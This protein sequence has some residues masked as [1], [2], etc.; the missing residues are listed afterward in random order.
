[1]K[2]FHTLIIALFVLVGT[3]ASQTISLTGTMYT[4]DFNTLSNTAGSTTN[5]LAIPGWFMTETGGGARDNEQY[6]VDPGGS[7]TGDTYSYGSA[8][9]TDRALGGLQAGTLIPNFGAAFT[10]NTGDIIS[11]IT[12]SYTGEQWRLGTAARTDQLNFEYSTNATDL[13]TGTWTNVAALNFVSPTTVTVG[14][15][16][17]NAA[18]NRTALTSNITG[19]SIANGATFWIRWADFN[20]TGADDGLSVDD[21]SISSSAGGPLPLHL[22]NFFAVKQ[23]QAGKLS[24]STE[25]EINSS[26]FVVERSSNNTDW[27]SIAQ[28]A[29]AGNS[30]A[31]L[32]YSFTDVN[33]LR[34]VN[35]Y[36]LQM[37]DKDNSITY[38]DIRRVNFDKNFSYSVYP[39]PAQDFILIT[40]DAKPGTSSAIQF[41]N[42]KGQVVIQQQVIAAMQ[43]YR[44]NVDALAAGFYYIKITAPDGT[45]SLL[46]F[47]K[48]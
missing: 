47:V 7:N 22:T 27:K 34:G 8:A 21:F 13:V 18:A 37:V 30:S 10:N 14:A 11:S 25:Q 48:Q 39:N 32:N 15:K 3:C 16:D 28:I 6:A 2:Q 29:A 38:S 5:V 43:P 26:F 41:I 40:T 19:L 44:V 35:L 42:A 33:P 4:Q 17:G 1:M 9:A 45:A 46:P 31:L 36:R 23:N 12:I 20:A 24:W